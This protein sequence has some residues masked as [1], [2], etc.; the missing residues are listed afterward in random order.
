[1]KMWSDVKQEDVHSKYNYFKS[2]LQSAWLSDT[3]NSF[4][5]LLIEVTPEV[6]PW[7]PK[8][9]LINTTQGS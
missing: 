7:F 2:A 6:L 1:M 5:C 3:E 9:C 8:L 4:W